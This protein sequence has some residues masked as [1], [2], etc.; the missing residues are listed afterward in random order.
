MTERFAHRASK[1]K[2]VNPKGSQLIGRTEAEVEAPLLR[3]PDAKSQL[4]AKEPDVG[5]D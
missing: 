4:F 5:K 2:P 3:P 1:I